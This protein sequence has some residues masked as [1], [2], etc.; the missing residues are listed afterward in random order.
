[1]NKEHQ[2]LQNIFEQAFEQRSS[3]RILEAGCGSSSYLQFG[4]N[5][6]ITGIDISSIQL[7]R[8]SRLDERIQGDLQTMDL[9]ETTFDCIICY[10]VLEHLS[11]PMDVLVKLSRALAVG[12]LLI[13]G[14]PNVI[15]TKGFV[16]KITPH[17]FHVLV[18]R[19]FYGL[20]DV[21]E[22]DR[23]PFRT[24]LRFTLRRSSLRKFAIDHGLRTIY[25]KQYESPV[26]QQSLDRRPALRLIW[27]L[28]RCI[29]RSFFLG[30][31][32]PAL[33][34]LIIVL[35]KPKHIGEQS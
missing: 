21:G 8:N 6:H 29:I 16:T 2:Q 14:L 9:P 10:D 23:G 7:K 24:Y 22:D 18:Y 25:F 1:M 4:S 20:Q 34:D 17:F 32:D 33:S 13:L 28:H 11:R 27:K 35:A 26:Q 30:R 3:I 31:I 12:G 15:S 19:N 5:A